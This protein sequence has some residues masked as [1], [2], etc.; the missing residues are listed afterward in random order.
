M[1]LAA[2]RQRV[3]GERSW[4]STEEAVA[5]TAAIE[6]GSR[7]VAAVGNIVAVEVQS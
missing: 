1:G 2:R 7:S 4:P 5:R 6:V 3:V